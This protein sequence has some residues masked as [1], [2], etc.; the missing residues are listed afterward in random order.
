V[1]WQIGSYRAALD[2]EREIRYAATLLRARYGP[3]WKREAP[4][5]L[6][7]MLRTGAFIDTA[8]ARATTAPLGPTRT[9]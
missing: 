8:C 1:L 4:A 2:T 5:E 3:R 9:A 6:V 7:W